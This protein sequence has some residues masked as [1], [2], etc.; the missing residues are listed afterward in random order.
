MPDLQPT[1]I[2]LGAARIR[3]QS[4]ALHVSE[5]DILYTVHGDTEVKRAGRIAQ[6]TVSFFTVP[7]HHLDR[8]RQT[9]SIGIAQALPARNLAALAF[10]VATIE[11]AFVDPIRTAIVVCAMT[12]GSNHDEIW[13]CVLPATKATP[14]DPPPSYCAWLNLDD[15]PHTATIAAL[16]P[17]SATFNP[18]AAHLCLELGPGDGFVWEPRKLAVVD[19]CSATNRPSTKLA[20]ASGVHVTGTDRTSA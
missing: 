1:V 4:T 11:P 7:A 5:R 17:S 9:A 2:D 3:L 14:R 8:Y 10:L 20:L 15:F 12:A 6:A 19:S 13:K 16:P 18:S